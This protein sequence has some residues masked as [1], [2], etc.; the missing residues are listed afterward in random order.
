V[1]QKNKQGAGMHDLETT[2]NEG[3]T[4][5]KPRICKRS[6]AGS[7]LNGVLYQGKFY[8]CSTQKIAHGMASDMF[9][10]GSSA[11]YGGFEIKEAK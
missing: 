4:T 3:V 7:L 11:G 10:E 6:V 8:P 5:K 2:R 9:E 1:S